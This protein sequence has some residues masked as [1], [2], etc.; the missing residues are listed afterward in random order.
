MN[1]YF[2]E[3]IVQDGAWKLEPLV[4]SYFSSLIETPD[5]RI[6]RPQLDLQ[7]HRKV[8]GLIPGS[9]RSPG[10]GYGYP[11]Q[12]SCLENSMDRGAWQAIVH[13]VTKS[14][15]RWSD[16]HFHFSQGLSSQEFLDRSSELCSN[17]DMKL[18]TDARNSSY[19][20]SE[21]KIYSQV[22]IICTTV[23]ILVILNF[24]LPPTCDKAIL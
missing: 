23:L 22:A 6:F 16:K 20:S 7:K 11:L 10:E 15:T 2:S 18:F 14:Q 8:L 24:L 5:K 4:L 3:L 13:G 1:F 9:E 19:F 17:C 21:R 12:Y